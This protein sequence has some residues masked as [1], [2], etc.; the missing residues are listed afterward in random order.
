MERRK[1]TVI[2][3]WSGK[4]VFHQRSEEGGG[5]NYAAMWAR[6]IKAKGAISTTDL[7]KW[8]CLPQV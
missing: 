7:R 3:I 4:V 5:T 8:I 1:G 2:V 6:G